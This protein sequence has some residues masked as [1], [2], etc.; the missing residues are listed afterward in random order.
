M[1][2][3]LTLYFCP[4][5]NFYRP[6]FCILS[7]FLSF[8]FHYLFKFGLRAETAYAS[9]VTKIT[10]NSCQGVGGELLPT[11]KY[12][13]SLAIQHIKHCFHPIM[14]TSKDSRVCV[15]THPRS[16]LPYFPFRVSAT[17]GICYISRTFLNEKVVHSN[18]FVTQ[19][20]VSQW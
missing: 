2:F 11:S 14:R 12:R 13:Y 8:V 20:R 1:R 4:C 3:C 17:C 5:Q 18:L 16:T 6:P 9:W 7:I 15:R 10:A 19:L